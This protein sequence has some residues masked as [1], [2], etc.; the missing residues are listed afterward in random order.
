VSSIIY[1]RRSFLLFFHRRFV[2]L[3]ARPLGF[4][5]HLGAAPPDGENERHFHA[6]TMPVRRRTEKI[7]NSLRREINSLDFFRANLVRPRFKAFAQPVK[8]EAHFD[9][10]EERYI[11]CLCAETYAEPS[12]K[13]G[14]N[15]ES[16]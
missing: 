11:T 2:V 13:C 3:A 9:L 12:N 7:A 6:P 5:L 15:A 16:E 4:N 1:E 14:L 8:R 10:P